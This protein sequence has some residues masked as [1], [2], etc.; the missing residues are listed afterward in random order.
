MTNKFKRIKKILDNMSYIDYD[1]V[2][3][4]K[5]S[6]II[7]ITISDNFI[8][9]IDADF[10]DDVMENGMVKF[11]GSMDLNISGLSTTLHGTDSMYKYLNIIIEKSDV[12]KQFIRKQKLENILK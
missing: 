11:Y 1:V 9:R 6:I 10:H 2:L 5:S 12:Y 7:D 3:N 8:C 4:V